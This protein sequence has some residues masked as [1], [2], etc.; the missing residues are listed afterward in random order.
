MLAPY[1]EAA[2]A[3]QTL[4]M[5]DA[6]L[7]MLPSHK[8]PPVIQT[9][10]STKYNICFDNACTSKRKLTAD[11]WT[12]TASGK[13][14]GRLVR[15]EVIDESSIIVKTT[16]FDIVIRHDGVIMNTDLPQLFGDHVVMYEI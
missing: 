9:R 12:N 1:F 5:T 16:L 3:N 14:L 2:A 8:L 4:S 11:K 6:P 15:H 13:N 10:H 7:K